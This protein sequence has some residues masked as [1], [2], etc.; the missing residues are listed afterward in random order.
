MEFLADENST[1]KNII[2]LLKKN[3]RM[4]IEE[5][6]KVIDITP[7]G[8]RQ[9][10]LSLEKKG[11]VTYLTK[12]C[13][14]G[15]PGFVYMLTEAA[16]DLFPKSYDSFAIGILRDIRK[17]DGHEKVDRI[18]GWRRE[19]LY[20][21]M[22]GALAG[23]ERLDDVLPALKRILEAEGHLVEIGKHNGHYFLRQFHCPLNKVA[24]E[25]ADACRHELQLYRDLI[26]KDIT[27]E[28]SI[29]DG[30]TACVYTIPQD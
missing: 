12:K 5:L 15:R 1:R 28:Q 13:G 19:R 23:K 9:H 22:K 25:F 29:A 16:D 14:I 26:N 17:H 10:L 27:R 2:F 30:E 8:I 7:M 24:Q 6:S 11:Y 3:G 4:S 20:T 21:L 18:F